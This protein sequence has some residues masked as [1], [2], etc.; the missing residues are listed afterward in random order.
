MLSKLVPSSQSIQLIEDAEIT[1]SMVKRYSL[2]R[3]S[4][5][6]LFKRRA[7]VFCVFSKITH[8]DIFSYVSSQPLA[9]FLKPDK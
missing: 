6:S 1:A 5:S 2:D 7:F 3:L 8:N 9:I 4:R